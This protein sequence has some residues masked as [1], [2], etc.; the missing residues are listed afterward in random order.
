MA[1]VNVPDGRAISPET[2][3]TKLGSVGRPVPGVEA[4]TVD[5]DT[6]ADLP[7]GEAGL[8]W[9]RGKNVM[10][11]YLNQPEKTAEVVRDGW[12]NTG[13]IAVID[14]EGFITITGRQSRFSKIGGEM[15]PHIRIEETLI[16][17]AGDPGE[18]GLPLLCVTA[19]PDP[20][21]GERLIVL[22][23]PFEKKIEQLLREFSETGVPNLWI[24][25][26]TAFFAVDGVPLLGS[27]KLD[28]RRIKELAGEC[29]NGRRHASEE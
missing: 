11:G 10:K 9:I 20:R 29:V 14:D 24:P 2:A 3:G 28:L 17:L 26:R 15:V 12:Y 22:H 16:R 21:K 5:P 25:D 19:V 18:D 4:K 13:D 1:A 27:G 6:F 7:S 8:L 23:R